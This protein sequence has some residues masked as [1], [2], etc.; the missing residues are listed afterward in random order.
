MSFASDS[1]SLDDSSA[2]FCT[3][4]ITSDVI[5]EE[6]CFIQSHD[7]RTE[8]YCDIL[9]PLFGSLLIHLCVSFC[10]FLPCEI[11]ATA[12]PSDGR[13]GYFDGKR[14]E[15]PEDC[16]SLCDGV[17]LFEMGEKCCGHS[18]IERTTNVASP[19]TSLTKRTYRSYLV[20]FI[21]GRSRDAQSSSD[22][23]HGVAL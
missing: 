8:A 14:L 19:R 12:I 18:L 7:M 22:L 6:S 13:Y 4:S 20:P 11:E 16:L 17:V 3:P 23:F 9:K 5:I 21:Q 2:A 1:W 15:D 10:S